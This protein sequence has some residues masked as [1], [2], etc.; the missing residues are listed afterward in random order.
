[1]DMRWRFS[2]ALFLIVPALAWL[3]QAED[4]SKPGPVPQQISRYYEDYS[5]VSSFSTPQE[6]TILAGYLTTPGRS[7]QSKDGRLEK[8]LRL[9]KNLEARVTN[10]DPKMVINPSH[11]LVLVDYE[12]IVEVNR[13]DVCGDRAAADVTILGLKPEANLWLIAQYE[14]SAGDPTRIP[15]PRLG[16]ERAKGSTFRQAET[17]TWIKTDGEWKKNEVNIVLLK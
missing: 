4:Q 8:V 13:V 7:Y 11:K 3:A 14:K 16:L 2:L 17:H 1:M 15:S 6:R 9:M 12:G 5:F 10:I